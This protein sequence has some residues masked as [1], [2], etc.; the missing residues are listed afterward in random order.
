MNAHMDLTRPQSDLL[1]AIAAADR[2]MSS[3]DMHSG[4]RD[5]LERRG[6]IR[7]VD[8]F[9]SGS[10]LYTITEEGRQA[11]PAPDVAGAYLEPHEYDSYPAPVP[12]WIVRCNHPSHGPIALNAGHHYREES[13]HHAELLIV[14]HDA[15]EHPTR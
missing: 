10:M 2:T 5:A 7:M 11:L 14:R 3:R 15:E 1:A 9:P 12:F 4:T 6:L 13:K 8:R